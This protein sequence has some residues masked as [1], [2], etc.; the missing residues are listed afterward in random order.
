MAFWAGAFCSSGYSICN[1]RDVDT[2]R[3]LR[4]MRPPQGAGGPRSATTPCRGPVVMDQK[5]APRVVLQLK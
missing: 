3:I 4:E 1:A 2:A 5:L